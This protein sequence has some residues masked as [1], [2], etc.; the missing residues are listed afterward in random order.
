MK[1]LKVLVCI[2]AVLSMAQL[3]WAALPEAVTPDGQELSDSELAVKLADRLER[4]PFMEDAQEARKWLTKWIIETPDYTLTLCVSIL[5]PFRK[6]DH[7]YEQE[8]VL[9]QVY[10][11]AAF[12]VQNPESEGDVGAA[13]LAGIK[14]ALRVY[15]SILKI[16]P[17][18]ARS[19]ILDELIIKRENGTLSSYVRK[20]VNEDCIP[21]AKK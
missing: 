21:S 14:G 3:S 2:L 11:G 5:G 13:N 1:K 10:S 8:I 17:E 18:E 12:I 6:N 9:Q 15:E 16:K 4:E 19:K 7:K 20:I